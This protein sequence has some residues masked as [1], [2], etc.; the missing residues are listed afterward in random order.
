MAAWSKAPDQSGAPGTGPPV[1]LTHD[2]DQPAFARS[3]VADEHAVT[4]VE[5]FGD[6]TEALVHDSVAQRVLDGRVE[7][8]FPGKARFSG[9]ATDAVRSASRKSSRSIRP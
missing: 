9:S 7:Q 5:H 4:G 3:E 8:P 1:N 6:L 2:H